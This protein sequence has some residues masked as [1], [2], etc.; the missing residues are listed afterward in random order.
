MGPR[1]GV[2]DQEIAAF[3]SSYRCT[4][5]LVGAGAACDL[6]IFSNR[7][8]SSSNSATTIAPAAM[9][10]NKACK[11]SA[12]R[13]MSKEGGVPCM[14]NVLWVYSGAQHIEVY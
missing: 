12:L 13:G 11:Q 3:G 2:E 7:M 9:T 10:N 14:E 6:L 8:T 1:V 5:S 4:H